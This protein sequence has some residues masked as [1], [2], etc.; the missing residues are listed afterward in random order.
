MPDPDWVTA[1]DWKMVEFMAELEPVLWQ[2]PAE[3]IVE[4]G[5]Y[6][7]RAVETRRDDECLVMP[8]PQTDTVTATIMT[9]TSQSTISVLKRVSR[10]WLREELAAGGM[11]NAFVMAPAG[12][13]VVMLLDSQDLI[14]DVREY[15]KRFAEGKDHEDYVPQTWGEMIMLLRTKGIGGSLR[16]FDEEAEDEHLKMRMISVW[17]GQERMERGI[18]ERDNPCGFLA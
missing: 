6:T 9:A 14:M 17:E 8:Y 10:H 12:S 7:I 16:P 13:K 1:A 5:E 3:K 15:D 18:E 11:K 4:H 2:Q